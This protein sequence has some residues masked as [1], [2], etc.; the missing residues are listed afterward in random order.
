MLRKLKKLNIDPD[1]TVMN[2]VRA[3]DQQP[4]LSVDQQ[5]LSVDDYQPT[6]P[7]DQQTKPGIDEQPPPLGVQQ[8]DLAECL[9]KLSLAS[10]VDPEK[11]P[12]IAAMGNIPGDSE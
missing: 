11:N 10:E 2:S 6:P 8:P 1:V 7:V 4:P 3:V 9:A 5:P 12:Q